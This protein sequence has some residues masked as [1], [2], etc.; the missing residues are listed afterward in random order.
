MKKVLTVVPLVAAVIILTIILVSHK[1]Q[2]KNL[3][4]P[5]FILENSNILVEDYCYGILPEDFDENT[6]LFSV[7]RDGKLMDSVRVKKMI[8]DIE[9]FKKENNDD[10]TYFIGNLLSVFDDGIVL[11]GL[12]EQMWYDFK[13]K[14]FYSSNEEEIARK[15]DK[16]CLKELDDL[17]SATLPFVQDE[18]DRGMVLQIQ[19]SIHSESHENLNYRYTHAYLKIAHD[20]LIK[21]WYSYKTDSIP[22][23][24]LFILMEDSSLLMDISRGGDKKAMEEKGLT[25]YDFDPSRCYRYYPKTGEF[26]ASDFYW[27]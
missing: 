2:P 27:E 5:K 11:D 16:L 6:I 3:P 13:T 14:K 4:K 26:S 24:N 15:I 23:I 17:L 20:N 18:K 21:A 10:S 9:G 8:K 22:H 7:Y 25:T 1:S 19:D 12:S